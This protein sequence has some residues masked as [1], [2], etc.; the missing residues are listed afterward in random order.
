VEK[1][2]R[3]CETENPRKAGGKQVWGVEGKNRPWVGGGSEKSEWMFWVAGN[4]VRGEKEKQKVSRHLEF[5]QRVVL[6]RKKTEQT[7]ALKVSSDVPRKNAWTGRKN[8]SE[9]ESRELAG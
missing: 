8:E 2:A 9:S 5:R 1:G 3:S 4:D 7:V 6:Y